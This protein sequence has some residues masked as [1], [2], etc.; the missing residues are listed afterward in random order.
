MLNKLIGLEPGESF[1]RSAVYFRHGTLLLVLAAC[2]VVAF[3]FYLYRREEMLSKW[4]RVIMGLC[5]AVAAVLLVIMLVEPALDAHIIKPMKRTVLVILDTSK[6]MGISDIRT[7]EGDM[8]DAARLTGI[9]GMSNRVSEV[10]EAA[11]AA[12]LVP[13]SRLELAQLAL[14]NSQ[15]NFIEKLAV[16]HDVRLFSCDETLRPE[17]GQDGSVAW[18]ENRKADGMASCIGSAI[19]EAVD[20]HAGQPVDGVV[21]LSDFAWTG[22]RDPAEVAANLK[23]RGIP[24]FTVGIGVSSQPDYSVRSIIAPDVAFAGD[25]IPVRVQVTS[26]GFEG[27]AGELALAVNG[28]GVSTQKVVFG[29]GVQFEEIIYKPQ[30]KSGMIELTV[31]VSGPPGEVSRD[32][33]SVSHKI[34][35]LDEKI[36]VLYVEGMPRWEYR[37]LRW[38]LLRDQRLNVKFL[39]TEGDPALASTSPRQ[40]A[41]FPE[42][43]AEITKY[44]LIILGD[45]PAKYFNATQLERIEELVRERGGSLLML[46]GPVGAP[47]SY[48]QTAI[49][50]VLPVKFGNEPWMTVPENRFPVVTP[51]GLE[52]PCT[53]LMSPAEA[54]ADLWS[55]VKPLSHVPV[56]EGAK[57]GAT[58]LLT[59]SGGIEGTRVYP[60]VAWQRY[61][62]GKAMFVG[63]EDM[64]RLRLEEGSTYHARFWG[65]TIQFLA[66]S[67]L[68]GANK[69]VALETDRRVYSTGEQIKIFA[70]V[71]TA[72][73]KAATEPSYKVLVEQGGQSQTPLE[74]ELEPVPNSPGLYSGTHLAAEDGTFIIK[75]LPVHKEVSN[76]I[77]FDVQT[78]ALEQ[79]ETDMQSTVATQVAGRSGGRTWRLS[80]LGALPAALRNDEPLTQS[81]HRERDLWDLPLFFVLLVI[82]TGIEWAMRRRD[83]LV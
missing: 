8:E 74:V 1:V 79:R 83:N 2:A 71:L 35:I 61:G 10:G 15:M 70:N 31:S 5:Q 20:R 46:A 33:N 27:K 32:N 55:R 80:E 47:A 6:S 38:V 69:Q 57:P 34:K 63:S 28:E 50:K 43:P 23:T 24:V 16:D 30:Q 52:S 82:V 78:T 67:R 40:L 3:A 41:K 54:N 75:T 42:D 60:L 11:V 72:S 36:N 51:D 62:N 68:L 48:T 77:Q 7:R 9:I 56:L 26:S 18:L 4:R 21:V 44:D 53:S 37:Y 65:Q 39:M 29:G 64:W 58:V 73:F 66:L 76:T 49:A 45:V 22:G 12:K 14:T 17:A 13:R 25:K 19:A 59:L 81:I